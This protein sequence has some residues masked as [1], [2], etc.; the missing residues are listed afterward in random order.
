MRSKN[1][2][3]VGKMSITEYEGGPAIGIDLGTTYSR[4]SVWQH[5]GVE[6]IVNDH[7]NRMTPSYVA[8]TDTGCL[9]G[10]A[11]AM[12]LTNI[13]FD[14]KRLI[15]RRFSDPSV[16][17]DMKQWPFKVVQG[18][19]DKP[20]I[21]VTYKGKGK[22]FSAEE[23]TSMVLIK[24]KE[25]AEAY[26]GTTVKNVVITVPANFND[27]Q[28]QATMD[29][30]V[31]AGLNVMRIINEPSAAAIAYWLDE[32]NVVNAWKKDVMVFH[33]GGGTFDVSLLTIGHE[34]GVREVKST[35]GDMHLGGE[36]FDNRMVDHFV[37]EF[38]A[39]TE[40]DISGDA[41][42]LR[43]LRTACE[44]AKR[45]L[46]S[47]AQTTIE[48]DSLYEG[49]DFYSTITRAKFEE[50]NVDLFSKSI[51]LVD[52]CL[53]DAKINVHE[54]VLVG[55]STRIPKVQQ[56]LQN[57]FKRKNLCMSINPDE[58]VAIGAAVHAARLNG[59]GGEKFQYLLWDVCTWSLG[60]NDGN[61][62][63]EVLIPRNTLTPAVK[64]KVL[65]TSSNN[66]QRVLIKVYEGESSRVRDNNLLG[67]FELS[68]I[69]PAP[70]GVPQ[71]SVCFGID[72]NGILKVSAEDNTTRQTKEMTVTNDKG[73]LLEKEIEKMTQEAK[74]YKAEDEEHKKKVEVKNALEEY[75]YKMRNTI[76][77][78]KIMWKVPA[79][80]SMRVEDAME[81]IGDTIK[82][83]KIG[84]KLTA[85]DKKKM[86]VA[87]EVI[88]NTIKGVMKDT[89]LEVDDRK[90]VDDAVKKALEWLEGNQH[91]EVIESE[92]V[93]RQL[94]GIWKPFVAMMY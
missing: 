67:K 60:M 38:M 34:E 26:L 11:A 36:D 22:R 75:A 58:A 52:R 24:M 27:S 64:K 7:G 29:A 41:R 45:T 86:E 53:N 14:V 68:R 78:D 40:K 90:K 43:R 32:M 92:R 65:S 93:L 5:D 25:L 33:M 89:K 82:D 48:I 10:E 84:S 62:V 79:D 55:G 76:N 31:I 17:R 4:V 46:S 8:F 13:V 72:V 54:V 30:G 69:P 57:F 88:R 21:V 66:Q 35:A 85:E 9:I 44:S 61:G 42:A 74:K 87:M 20:I 23:I 50:L 2:E 77:D 28:R 3:G 81:V 70:R 71:I 16:Q 73:R 80:Y 63:M 19:G 6:I 39:K 15:G 1:E 47:T 94:E 59:E 56:L 51:E 18:A 37:Q 91:A 49:I 12:N 83:D